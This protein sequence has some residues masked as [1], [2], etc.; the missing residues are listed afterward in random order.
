MRA[1]VRVC[2]DALRTSKC[3]GERESERGRDSVCVSEEESERVETV[4]ASRRRDARR[5][6]WSGKQKVQGRPEVEWHK[7]RFTPCNGCSSASEC[8]THP[9]CGSRNA[10]C[11]P[12]CVCVRMCE[13]KTHSRQ[14][15]GITTDAPD[16]LPAL[17]FQ[18]NSME[19]E[20]GK[21]SVKK[22][23][24]S[25]AKSPDRVPGRVKWE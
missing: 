10:I 11:V 3:E 20:D 6:R 15:K 22:G 25:E 24:T 17:A 13:V 8:G 5:R 7:S 19:K 2:V 12:V 9:P 16:L 18:C 4:C 21:K 23:A 14:L 1:C